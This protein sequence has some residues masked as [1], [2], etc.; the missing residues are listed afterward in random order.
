MAKVELGP[1]VTSATGT[2][3]TTTFRKRKGVTYLSRKPTVHHNNEPYFMNAQIAMR[4]GSMLWGLLGNA[5]PGVGQM[6]TNDFHDIWNMFTS[7]PGVEGRELFIG[8]YVQAAVNHDDSRFI[9]LTFGTRRSTT[10]VGL[11]L[12]VVN[13]RQIMI[14]ILTPPALPYDSVKMGVFVYC[15]DDFSPLGDPAFGDNL[16]IMG[17]RRD[18]Q[19]NTRYSI[20]LTVPEG[21]TVWTED[22]LYGATMFYES[23]S[24]PGVLRYS[25]SNQFHGIIPD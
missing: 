18:L 11:G 10:V 4:N 1:F 2:V 6:I 8:R 9:D 3:G 17:E 25:V 15:M 7:R 14:E 16:I 24:F 19:P 5:I 20:T 12:I 23:E 22:V 13:P 21:V